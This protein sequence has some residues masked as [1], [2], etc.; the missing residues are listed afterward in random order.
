MT[1]FGPLEFVRSHLKFRKQWK[2]PKFGTQRRGTQPNLGF[3]YGTTHLSLE[4]NRKSTYIKKGKNL[5][6]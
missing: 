1:L 5:I 3:W 2:F 6:V 4:G